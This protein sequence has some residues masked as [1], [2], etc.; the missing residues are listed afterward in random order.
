MKL[1]K[2]RVRVIPKETTLKEWLDD[3]TNDVVKPNRE[4]GTVYTHYKRNNDKVVYT[5]D[6]IKEML[7]IGKNQAYQLSKSGQFHG[8]YVGEKIVVLKEVFRN[9]LNGNDQKVS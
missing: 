2:R 1:T 5:V 8:C 9:W 7:G 3:W 4:D 6:E